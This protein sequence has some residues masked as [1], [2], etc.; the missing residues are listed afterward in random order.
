M[1]IFGKIQ[2]KTGLLERLSSLPMVHRSSRHGM[3]EPH[4][5]REATS[6]SNSGREPSRGMGELLGGDCDPHSGHKRAEDE[7]AREPRPRP[8]T[9]LRASFFSRV[10]FLTVLFLSFSAC[11]VMGAKKKGKRSEQ[12]LGNG[13]DCPGLGKRGSLDERLRIAEGLAK[14]NLAGAMACALNAKAN[15]VD[16]IKRRA[17]SLFF[18]AATGHNTQKPSEA[19]SC[20]EGIPSALLKNWGQ[21]H[22]LLG[23]L[24][25]Q[26]G[27]VKG[28][29][30]SLEQ[31]S[32]LR[33]SE[34]SVYAALAQARYEDQ[35][36][37]GAEVVWERGCVMMPEY[38]EGFFN[39]GLLLR[40]LGG[41][42]EASK[43]GYM[44]AI[45]LSPASA[46]YRYSYGNLLYDLGM[47]KPAVSVYRAALRLDPGHDDAS[48]NLGNA[49]RLLGFLGHARAVFE[50]SLA[51]SP[52]NTNLLLNAGQVYQDLGM[53]SETAEVG[54]LHHHLRCIFDCV[55]E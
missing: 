46:R 25:L 8:R 27:N 34:P 16:E 43:K 28:A 39:V 19:L 15:G 14:T 32:Y 37:Q 53:V 44:T 45:R 26:H 3:D 17:E 21:A 1:I 2:G 23:V 50:D 7:E 29:I 52:K 9:S 40:E 20:M 35:D 24:R 51:R 22:H 10:L 54:A 30:S 48:N 13:Q 41:R 12:V 5:S 47:L 11:N 42:F 33:P 4:G 31:A 55:W 36:P 38:A 49:L 18:L 6:G